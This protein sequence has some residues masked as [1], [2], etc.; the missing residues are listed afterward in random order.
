VNRGCWPLVDGELVSCLTSDTCLLSQECVVIGE[1]AGDPTFVCNRDATD[2]CDQGRGA[3]VVPE[4]ACLLAADCSASTYA[5][6]AAEIAELPGAAAAISSVIMGSTPDPGALTP[7]GPAL[8]GALQQAAAWATEHPN[9]QVVAVLATDGL[10]TLQEDTGGVC[11]PITRQQEINSVPA[12]ARTA[13]N[14][15]PPISTFVIGVVGAADAGATET[16]GNIARLG[17]TEQA[18]I[19]DPA[20][21]VSEQF[22]AALEAIRGKRLACELEVPTSNNGKPVDYLQVNVELDDGSGAADLYY[23]GT[24]AG[25]DSVPN[26]WYYDVPDPTAEA[27]RRIIACPDTCAA[28]SAVET[29]SVQIQLGCATRT[30][31]VK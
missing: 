29:G 25:C 30:P 9:H 28:F 18:F 2:M 24:A 3:C 12:L 16:L 17:G 13:L 11:E 27:P 8:K 4:S 21:N 23:V 7:T 19:V 1:C 5:A 14:G 6:P 31:V 10:P 22:R 15:A 20:G 26:G